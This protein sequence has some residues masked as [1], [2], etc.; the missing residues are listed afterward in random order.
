MSLTKF[1][2]K[3]ILRFEF[4]RS[5]ALYQKPDIKGLETQF[6]SDHILAQFFQLRPLVREAKV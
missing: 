4:D 5:S 3:F 6:L 2:L 1:L